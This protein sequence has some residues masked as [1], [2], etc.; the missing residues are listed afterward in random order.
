MKK[1]ILSLLVAVGLIGGPTMGHASLINVGSPVGPV[2]PTMP[3]NGLVAFYDFKGNS[4]NSASSQ[5]IGSNVGN[6]TYVADRFNNP[7]SA[8]ELSGSNSYIRITNLISTNAPYTWSA[9]FKTYESTTNRYVGII[10]QG[11]DPGIGGGG[12]ILSLNNVS[13]IGTFNCSGQVQAYNYSTSKYPN[14][15]WT[16][17]SKTNAWNTN[18]WYH[19]AFTMQ[20][21][22][23][24]SLYV[25]G[26][27]ASSKTNIPFG[28]VSFPTKG[29]TYIGLAAG[30]LPAYFKGLI[31][32]VAIYNRALSSNEVSSLY[33]NAINVA[34]G[35]IYYDNVSKHFWG[36]TGGTN[37]WKQ[38]DN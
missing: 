2:S 13:S 11:S 25:N 22:G 9:W 26:Q 33:T 6:I 35:Q 3:T 27:L 24:T 14:Y 15:F 8:I 34:E 20:T 1:L 18:L 10:S 12:Q 28:D 5:F 21:N 38:L 16:S 23:T 32:D 17:S 31:D 7:S 30:G 29:N 19:V 4:S 36:F 37:G